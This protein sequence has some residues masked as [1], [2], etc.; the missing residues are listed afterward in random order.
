MRKSSS[1]WFVL[2]SSAFLFSIT[3]CGGSTADHSLAPLTVTAITPSQA[4]QNSA[5]LTIK[6]SGSGFGSADQV[7][8]GGKAVTASVV[9]SSEIDITLPV[10]DLTISGSFPIA[11]TLGE[12]SAQEE[13]TVTVSS[14]SNPSLITLDNTG[15]TTANAD[16]Y[17]V[18]LSPDGRFVAFSSTATNLT[19]DALIA[20]PNIF[21]RD[22]CL[23]ADNTC[24]PRTLLI[25]AGYGGG[26]ADGPSGRYTNGDVS[27]TSVSNSGRYVAFASEAD[28]LTLSDT[29]ASRDV[30]V[31]DTCLGAQGM[32]SPQTS[33]VSA[34]L[35]GT[36]AGGL[37][38]NPQMTPNGRY[39][40]FESG[41]MDLAN[42]AGGAALQVFLRD[43]CVGATQGCTSQTSLLSRSATGAPGNGISHSASISDD[44][45]LVAFSSRSTNLVSSASQGFE[46]IFVQPIC[47]PS[48]F[49]PHLSSKAPTGM[50]ANGASSQPAISGDGS[51]LAFMTLATNILAVS[52]GNE[53]DVL[54][55]S[56]C[57]LGSVCANSGLIASS[58]LPSSPAINSLPQLSMDGTVVVFL[59]VSASGTQ[60]T[61][62]YARVPCGT[63]NGCSPVTTLVSK[64]LNG[65]P[66]SINVGLFALSQ[67]SRLV[68]FASADSGFTTLPTGGAIQLYITSI[69]P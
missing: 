22:T 29:N 19:T 57:S 2:L 35:Q 38:D 60:P 33:L 44:G 64:A 56:L 37:S 47:T 34:N 13:F 39:V 40:A 46:N 59:A 25:S 27:T 18:S 4:V 23:G 31:R 62:L 1:E 11:V 10:Q 42:P 67:S 24:K 49:A 26:P 69:Q 68:A 3:G 58:D 15:T 7:T 61:E 54:E 28:N 12:V 8:F 45:T 52:S 20:T 32:C 17:A 63:G 48:C 36:S 21:L 53:A 30:F 50:P 14:S 65:N 16:S 41:A 55:F 5:A 43:T 6:I 51:H 66:S 9:S